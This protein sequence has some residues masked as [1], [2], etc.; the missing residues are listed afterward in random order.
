[1]PARRGRALRRWSYAG[2]AFTA[3]SRCESVT[4]AVDTPPSGQV[5]TD[6]V[7]R[8]KMLRTEPA[9]G[10]PPRSICAWTFVPTSCFATCLCTTSRS[11]I[12]RA[13][14]RAESC[15]H[16]RVGIRRS[17]EPRRERNLRS[18]TFL[19]ARVRLGGRPVFQIL[20]R[21]S[22]ASSGASQGR[23]SSRSIGVSIL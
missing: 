9:C 22:P 23:E 14:V 3:S 4:V 18:A 10:C 19:R 15:R 2:R 13:A 16:P 21:E 17:A 11:W 6:R 7:C 5:L 1:M 8:V 12:F 20:A